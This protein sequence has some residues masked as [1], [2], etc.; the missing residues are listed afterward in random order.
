MLLLYRLQEKISSVRV[1]WFGE[2]DV[3]QATDLLVK[4]AGEISASLLLEANYEK[5]K[6]ELMEQCG[7]AK[8]NRMSISFFKICRDHC[9]SIQMKVESLNP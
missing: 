8:G 1:S 4:M 9:L 6:L 7:A 5:R 3:Q 2:G